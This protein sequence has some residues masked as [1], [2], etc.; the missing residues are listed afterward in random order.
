[1]LITGK[2]LENKP[3]PREC[4]DDIFYVDD[5]KDDWNMTHVEYGLAHLMR[6]KRIDR[7]AAL[8]DFDVEK[9]AMLRETFRIPG[10]G[11]TTHRYFRDK[12]AMRMKAQEE[13]VKVPAFTSLFHDEDINNYMAKHSAPWLVK[14][15]AEA[16]ATGIKKVHSSEEAWAHIH[17]LGDQR[18][19]FLMEQFK[20]GD[21]Y[22]IDAVT[23]NGK[24]MFVRS[25]KYLSTP[26][27]VAH[28]G[29]IFR[30]VTLPMNGTEDK[31]LLKLNDQ[32][33]KAF[34][35]NY[36]A[37]H[38][39]AIRC[40][41]DGEYYFLETSSR[42]GGANLAEMVEAATS[43]NLWREWA[44]I[45]FAQG[46]NTTY[47]APKARKEY[48]GIVVSL[49]REK[50]IDHRHYFNAPEVVWTMSNMEYHAGVIVK[51]SDPKRVMELL[52]EYAAIIGRDLHASAPPSSKPSN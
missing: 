39:E 26:F 22:H 37:S 44:K 32:V 9:G 6:K 28:G 24:V 47:E 3:W 13:G 5:S 18:H 7:I 40:H 50:N 42:V 33:L 21:V 23:N 35:M 11:Q 15:R 27:E 41:E 34:G 19:N 1:M 29:G 51:S 10:M 31:A 46:T 48:A 14:P 36:S 16:S 49:I 43:V 38:T 45:E 17:S 2:K 12:L 8:D 20:P 30:S 52:D 25:S 4:I